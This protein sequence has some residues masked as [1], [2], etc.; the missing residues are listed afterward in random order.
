MKRGTN[1]PSCHSFNGHTRRALGTEHEPANMLRGRM[2]EGS[3]ATW[4]RWKRRRK[5]K[6]CGE[7]NQESRV[8]WV[9]WFFWPSSFSV[10]MPT[11]RGKSVS[12]HKQENNVKYQF[13]LAHTST[14]LTV[15]SLS[16]IPPPSSSFPPHLIPP[17]HRWPLGKHFQHPGDFFLLTETINPHSGFNSSQLSE[18][19]LQKQVVFPLLMNDY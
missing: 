6:I 5:S 16:V 1:G 10:K 9:L 13:Y 15:H 12:L 17:D 2:W 11:N 14:Y 4:W 18:S 8:W 3:E 7:V 19:H